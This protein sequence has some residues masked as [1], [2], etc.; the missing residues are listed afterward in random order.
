[1]TVPRVYPATGGIWVHEEINRV[2]TS[3]YYPTDQRPSTYTWYNLSVDVSGESGE[4][5]VFLD[6]IYIFSHTFSTPNRTGHTG[7]Y[8]GNSSEGAYF[9]N[10][11]SNVFLS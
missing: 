8:N 7:V 11:S 6:G 10:F 9:D 4:V 2:I 5:D 3:T 1:M